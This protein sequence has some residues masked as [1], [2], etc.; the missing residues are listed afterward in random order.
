MNQFAEAS[1]GQISIDNYGEYLQNAG[2]RKLP[3]KSNVLKSQNFSAED[4]STISESSS[5]LSPMMPAQVSQSPMENDSLSGKTARVLPCRW[6]CDYQ[7]PLVEKPMVAQT[8][9]S[10]AHDQYH[11]QSY[12]NFHAPQ[13][14]TRLLGW[15]NMS[16]FHQ[17][18][19]NLHQ[20][21]Q[22]WVQNFPPLHQYQSSMTQQILAKM[23]T[24]A[25]NMTPFLDPMSYSQHNDNNVE[26][27][28]AASGLL[29]PLNTA[30]VN[31]H[32]ASSCGVGNSIMLPSIPGISNPCTP[33]PY[34]P[35]HYLVQSS[36]LPPL[37]KLRNKNTEGC[38]IPKQISCTINPPQGSLPVSTSMKSSTALLEDKSST[39]SQHKLHSSINEARTT[40]KKGTTKKINSDEELWPGNFDYAEYGS[41]GGSNLYV[42][43]SANQSELKEKLRIKKITVRTIG[44]TSQKYIY[45]VIFD[46]HL[47]ARKA[48]L[49]QREL[50]IRMIPP[51]NSRRNW[52]RNPS[53]DFLVKFE[54]K[55]RLIVKKGKADCHDIVGD[56]LMSNS[57]E[58]KGCLIWADQLK[59][60]RIRVVKCEGNFM[61]PGG[62]VVAMKGVS[63]K[64]NKKKSVG[65]IS[66]RCRHSRELFVTRRSSNSLHDYIYEESR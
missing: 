7:I 43:W 23:P 36:T 39:V 17:T 11:P 46:N 51:R 40:T 20:S 31:Y 52:L 19:L 35:M 15:G 49:L 64:S 9:K 16:P 60:H 32:S 8:S 44:R 24:M 33:M 22:S 62:R 50:Q 29:C 45:N 6:R 58:Q 3:A 56:L 66:Y 65:W 10:V 28:T 48:F 5:N 63:S 55:F 12:L 37:L 2:A 61:F 57:R 59:G 42:T 38:V 21:N 27:R 14:G 18:Q 41:N 1:G 34:T 30:I 47:S 54:T 4:G 53:P 13:L 25:P 26:T